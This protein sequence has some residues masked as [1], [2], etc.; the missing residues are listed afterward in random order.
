MNKGNDYNVLEK[1]GL[2]VPIYDVF[3]DASIVSSSQKK[4]LKSVVDK[5]LSTGSGYV[6]LR[7]E[8]K[9]NVSAM[10]NYPHIMP[11]QSA[12]AVIEAMRRVCKDNPQSSWWFLVN[13]AFE[14]HLWSAVVMLT[15]NQLRPGGPRLVG[16]VNATDNL[17]LRDAMGQS[18]HCISIEAWHSQDASWLRSAIA[19]SGL[20]DTWLEVSAVRSKGSVRRVFWG[21]R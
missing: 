20:L 16:E 10:G 5:I 8:P 3:D 11:L 17:P 13:E 9:H 2:P 19:R 15:E 6:G 21:I 1:A 14:E 18:D 4:R 12:D 7:T